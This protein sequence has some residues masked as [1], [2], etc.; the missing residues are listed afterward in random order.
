[1]GVDYYKVLG[2]PRNADA[3]TIKKA[4]HK[5]ALHYHPDKNSDNREEA[6]KKFKLIGEAYDVLSDEKKKSIYDA[7]GEEGLKNGI[8]ESSGAGSGFSQRGGSY[9]FSTND[10][11]KV[12]TQMFGSNDLYGGDLF[13]G[14]GPGFTRVFRS[15]RGFGFDDDFGTP[16]NSPP[17]DV[18]PVEFAFA[19][20]LEE[21]FA[22]CTKK[23][24]VTRTMPQ[25][26][27]VKEFEVKVLPGYKKGTK[28]RFEREG[29]V[30]DGYPPNIIADMVF[31]LDEKEHPRFK[32]N[33]ADLTTNVSVPLK[34]ALLGT[35]VTVK[36]IDGKDIP[37][38]LSGVSKNGRKIKVSGAGM[39]DR[40]TN[41]RGDLFVV[42]QVVMPTNLSAA[43]RDRIKACSF[44]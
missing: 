43:D 1:M 32:R 22:G 12:F 25:G 18:P 33:G 31:M 3:S 38:Q 20:T 2:V 10:A 19:C 11:F 44:A 7:Y 14:G 26:K 8:P 36:G 29:G 4:Y 28:I 37:I 6:E 27:S 15:S 40:K 34:E 30:V 9:T 5:L 13:G 23:F 16:Q 42:V 41:G 21:I 24:K 35:S 17:A 39:P